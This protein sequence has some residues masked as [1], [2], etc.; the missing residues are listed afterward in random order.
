[1]N[2][3]SRLIPAPLA[4]FSCLPLLFPVSQSSSYCFKRKER[5][6][7]LKGCILPIAF[8]RVP[9]VWRESSIIESKEGYIVSYELTLKPPSTSRQERTSLQNYQV[10]FV[11]HWIHTW[12]IKCTWY[13]SQENQSNRKVPV[14]FSG[15]EY[16]SL[17]GY[18]SSSASR[19]TVLS[20]LAS[21]PLERRYL[22]ELTS[23]H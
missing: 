8:K 1:M 19:V 9:I 22:P 6:L 10:I 4:S 5:Y 7:C 18:E 14:L 15:A 13:R 20:A 11:F 12:E 3:L 17:A 2:P 16:G 21:W 23:D